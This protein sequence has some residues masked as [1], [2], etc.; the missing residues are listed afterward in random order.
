MTTNS[1]KFWNQENTLFDYVDLIEKKIFVGDLKHQLSNIYEESRFYYLDLRE[2]FV[3]QDC[4]NNCCNNR[5]KL[6]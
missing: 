1:R 6:N 2:I 3:S 5:I 4:C